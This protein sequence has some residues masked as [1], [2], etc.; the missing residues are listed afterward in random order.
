MEGEVV[1]ETEDSRF[2]QSIGVQLRKGDSISVEVGTFHKIH[3]IGD[4]PSCYMYTF[5]R[6]QE[7]VILEN[8]NSKMVYSAFPFIE[9]IEGRLTGFMMMWKH[10]FN[11][12]LNLSFGTPFDV[13]SKT[14]KK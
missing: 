5:T 2:E 11:A 1:Y 4:S 8:E 6:M 13:R 9:D 12:V 3:T 14:S 7:D 10:I